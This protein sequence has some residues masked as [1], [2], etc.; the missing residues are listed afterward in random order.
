MR[1]P[2]LTLFVTLLTA[3][4]LFGA[5]IQVATFECDVTPPLGQPIYS[6]FKPL[7]EV[8]HPL[9]AKGVIL[10]DGTTRC[11]LC[12]V[13][14]CELC[15]DAFA[16][17]RDA[18]AKA[19]GVDPSRVAVQAVH[20]H[21]APITSL[22]ELILLGKSPEP[23]KMMD[24]K[25]VTGSAEKIGE[26]VAKACESFVECDKVGLGKAKVDR[27]AAI[28]RL[29]SEDGKALTRY[30]SCRD[31]K[32]IAMPEGPI[33]PF[34][35]TITFA[36][37]DKP[38]AR[39]H[40]Y[41]T[42]PQ[43]FYGDPRASY[44]VPGIAR[45][46]IE[47]EEGVMQ[48]YF[49]GCGG[50]VTMGKYNDGSKEA[51]TDLAKRLRAGMEESIAATEWQPAGKIDWR[52]VPWKMVPRTDGGHAKETA[53]AVLNDTTATPAA[54]W[55]AALDLDFLARA[56]RPIELTALK[57]GDMVILNLPGESFIEFQHYA[58]S[59]LPDDSVAVAAYGDCAPGYICTEVAFSEGGYE[60]TASRVVPESEAA[61]KA[62]IRE[63][64]GAKE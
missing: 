11:V 15:N 62:A 10:D 49:T 22:G 19:A 30:S 64:L 31:P 38:V 47:D 20:Q 17:V 45:E 28:R 21:T 9:L 58:Q 24:P 56:D 41:A 36:A 40:Y 33:D 27:V 1:K 48:I 51:R 5:G 8:E 59:L 18:I 14:Y 61:F 57:I 42:H 55:G 50:N 34:V 7:A 35:K 29:T 4:P 39:L 52:V 16:V 2:L 44:D 54:R 60:P 63:V 3:L 46:A 12:A 25:V 13:D 43:S 32:L 6:S 23:P 26:A 37:G 53:L